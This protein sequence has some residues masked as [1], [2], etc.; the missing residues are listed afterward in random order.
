MIARAKECMLAVVRYLQG[1]EKHLTS[2]GIF[3]AIVSIVILHALAA[4]LVTV[5]NYKHYF[6]SYSFCL[7]VECIREVPKAFDVQIGLIKI[8]VGTASFV[9]VM[10]GSYLAL[11]SYLGAQEVGAFGNKIAHVGLF[12][13]F[14]A[15]ELGRRKRLNPGCVDVYAIYQLMFPK[16]RP[17]SRF[18][19]SDFVDAVRIIYNVVSESSKAHDVEQAFTFERHRR[20]MI[21][22]LVGLGIEMDGLPRIDFL[23]VEDEVLDFLRMLCVV[24]GPT[25]N[26]VTLPRRSYR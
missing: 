21:A 17:D 6:S 24:F 10:F 20:R 3:L 14:I 11:R 13:R 26:E 9:A 12:E 22:A 23:E 19:S 8:G 18:A 5:V 25:D 16:N 7:S 15:V 4:G 1:L 2:S